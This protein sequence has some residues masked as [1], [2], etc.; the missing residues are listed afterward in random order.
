MLCL[1]GGMLLGVA[2]GVGLTLVL[3]LRAV[4][5]PHVAVVPGPDDAVLRLILTGGIYTGNA[6][7]TYDAAL[8]LVRAAQP[9]PHTVDLDLSRVTRVTI[10]LL[11]G[12]R[13][14]HDQ[15]ALDSVDLHVTGASPDLLEVLRRWPWWRDH[16]GG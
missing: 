13:A 4:N 16:E 15:L 3:V 12:L 8:G 9:P 11:D 6:Q 14:F 5:Q 7:V 1:T 10:P 2:A